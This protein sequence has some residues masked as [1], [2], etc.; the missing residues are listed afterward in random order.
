MEWPWVRRSELVRIEALLGDALDRAGRLLESER[1]RYDGLV[2]RMAQLQRVGFTAPVPPAVAP[3]P[4]DEGLPEPVRL[5]L[6][7][8]VNPQ[9]QA[10]RHMARLAAMW[11]SAGQSPDVV[12]DQILRGAE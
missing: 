7:A 9:S 2:E 8:R 1:G 3:P 10:G 4:P 6:A 11:L 12:A 5:A